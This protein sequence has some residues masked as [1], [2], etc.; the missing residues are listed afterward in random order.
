MKKSIILFLVLTMCSS[1]SE[2]A[3]TEIPEDTETTSQT[4]EANDRNNNPQSTRHG[5]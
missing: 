5:G 1:G 3:Q 2:Q 4:V